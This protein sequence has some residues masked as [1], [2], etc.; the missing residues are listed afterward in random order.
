MSEITLSLINQEIDSDYIIDYY[1]KEYMENKNIFF[2]ELIKNGILTIEETDDKKVTFLIKSLFSLL[3]KISIEF[4]LT[5]NLELSEPIY[6]INEKDIPVDFISENYEFK[7]GFL[8]STNKKSKIFKKSE[9]FLNN[10]NTYNDFDAKVFYDCNTPEDLDGYNLISVS[11]D[12]WKYEKKYEKVNLSKLISINNH[13]KSHYLKWILSDDLSIRYFYVFEDDREKEL[14]F[15]L[16]SHK[17]KEYILLT[18]KQAEI[19]IDEL[20]IKDYFEI[21]GLKIKNT[22]IKYIYNSSGELLKQEN[23]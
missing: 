10:L 1:E 3:N 9:K 11:N 6:N 12:I 16:K 8:K 5:F 22:Y 19:M 2:I 13:N 23:I 17:H 20:K 15:F 18:E 4:E 21:V 14:K 7:N